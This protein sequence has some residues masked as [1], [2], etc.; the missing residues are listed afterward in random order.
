VDTHAVKFI[1]EK[2][3]H[4]IILYTCIIFVYKGHKGIIFYRLNFYR[5]NC[6]DNKAVLFVH[7]MSARNL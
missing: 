3:Y 4:N 6:V 2:L 1:A 5:L 7:K